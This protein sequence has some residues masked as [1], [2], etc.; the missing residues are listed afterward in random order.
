MDRISFISDRQDP[1]ERGKPRA[2]VKLVSKDKHI[3]DS[4]FQ[5]ERDLESIHGEYLT[6]VILKDQVLIFT[7][8]E[9]SIY[10]GS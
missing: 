5:R 9:P 4:R 8:G 7:M 6:M 2:Y 10:R 1:Q 3:G